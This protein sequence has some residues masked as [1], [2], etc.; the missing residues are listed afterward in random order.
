[1]IPSAASCLQVVMQTQ[2]LKE[3]LAAMTAEKEELEQNIEEFR[4][5]MHQK[6]SQ[7]AQDAESRMHD[8][9]KSHM[10]AAEA[11]ENMCVC[12]RLRHTAPQ[13]LRK[14]QPFSSPSAGV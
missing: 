2:K 12:N 10:S 1:M 3:E 11:L 4:N 14:R 5:E 7:A 13:W 6:Q 8:L 9:E